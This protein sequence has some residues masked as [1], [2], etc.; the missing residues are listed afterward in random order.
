MNQMRASPE[1]VEPRSSS[2]TWKSAAAT[3][4]QP[5]VSPTAAIAIA[6]ATV[7]AIAIQPGNLAHLGMAQL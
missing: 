4:P 2:H 6:N 5:P 3:S 7:H 1:I